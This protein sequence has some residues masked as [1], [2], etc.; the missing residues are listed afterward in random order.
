MNQIESESKIEWITKEF[1]ADKRLGTCG[2]VEM[3]A[4]PVFSQ[5]LDGSAVANRTV[6]F[7]TCESKQLVVMFQTICIFVLFVKLAIVETRVANGAI[8]A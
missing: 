2:A 5:G 6:T 8:E 3:V 4:M 7:A 1:A